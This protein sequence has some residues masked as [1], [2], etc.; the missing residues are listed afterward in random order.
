MVHPRAAQVLHAGAVLEN[1]DSKPHVAVATFSLL[2][3]AGVNVATAAATVTVPAE[4]TAH[5]AAALPSATVDL[6]SVKTPQLY[7]L[8]I[9]VAL[10]SAGGVAVDAVNTSVGFRSLKY[11]ADKGLFINEAHTKVRGYVRIALAL[12]SCVDKTLRSTILS[13]VVIVS[14]DLA[15]QVLRSRR[16]R[17][18]RHGRARP[19][20]ALPCAGEPLCR[21]KRSPDLAQC[22]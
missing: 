7:T 18:R 13:N 20:Q 19:H 15:G 3:A 12:M 9:A 6:W 21:R 10:S 22:P 17:F 16:L 8:E 5:A 14:F 11:T 4:G 2:S 1:F